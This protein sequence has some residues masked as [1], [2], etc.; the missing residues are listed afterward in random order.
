MK[1]L[2]ILFCILVQSN[3]YSQS[4][5]P[6]GA[7]HDLSLKNNTIDSS[8]VRIWYAFNATDINNEETYDD[9]QRLDIGSHISKYYSFL[10][11]R[12][13][14]LVSEWLKKHPKATSIPHTYVKIGKKKRWNEYSYSEY[15]KDFNKNVFTEY[16]RMPAR[17]SHQQYSENISIQDWKIYEDTMVILGYLCQKATCRFRGRN[18]TAWFSMDIPIQNG[19]WKFGGLPGL[20]LKAYDDDELYVF[21]CV[22]IENFKKKYP[23][24]IY[25]N[26]KNYEKTDR[27]KFHKLLKKVYDDYY[28]VAGMVASN[29]DGSPLTWKK[30]PYNPLELE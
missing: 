14:S 21:E 29:L 13:D 28:T 10:L 15:F 22:K 2:V 8:N 19:P 11:F 12:N 4:F 9:L 7:R 18:Y 3:V 16:V 30:I 24:T 27:Q 6:A 20:I 25:G 1:K 17:V 5:V 23:V 26:C